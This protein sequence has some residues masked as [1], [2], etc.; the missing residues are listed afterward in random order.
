[1]QKR[2]AFLLLLI[3]AAWPAAAQTI[4][5]DNQSPNLILTY[6]DSMFNSRQYTQALDYYT[7]LRDKGYGSPAMYLKMAYIHEGLGRLGE[8]LYCLNLYSLASHDP[9]AATKMIELAEKNRLEGYQDEPFES[10]RTPLREYFLP[11]TGLLAT[12]CLLVISLLVNRARNNKSPSIVLAA[13]FILLAS[14][15]YL[16]THYSRDSAFAIVTRSHTY[17]MSGP[18]AAANVIEIIGEGHRLHVMGTQD[19]W[20]KVE[21]KDREVFVRDFLVKRVEL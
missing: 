13:L 20:L 16:H 19:V 1:M 2:T 5:S 3:L 4:P 21:W 7:T 18:S 8:S 11:I 14:V 10:L 17:L 15:L 9:Q 6:A 12:L